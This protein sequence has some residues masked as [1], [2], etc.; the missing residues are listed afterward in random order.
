MDQLKSRWRIRVEDAHLSKFLGVKP[1]LRSHH[2]L[3]IIHQHTAPRSVSTSQLR[4]KAFLSKVVTSEE[5]D[6]ASSMNSVSA[7][8]RSSQLLR[9]LRPVPSSLDDEAKEL[10]DIG[11]VRDLERIEESQASR[12]R[13]LFEEGGDLGDGEVEFSETEEQIGQ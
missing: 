6:T 12:A 4:G 5:A 1:D 11:E 3:L 8:L 7:G 9:D 10:G 2:H 13:V